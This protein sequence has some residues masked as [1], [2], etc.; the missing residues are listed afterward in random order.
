MHVDVNGARMWFD[1]EGPGL[2][3]DGGEMRQRPTVVLLHGGPGVFDHSYLKPDYARLADVAQVVYLDLLGHGRSEWGDPDAWTFEAAAD[4]VRAF[5]DAVGIERPV[6]LG[7]S[8]GTFVALVYG[9]R[10]PDHPAALV[11][12]SVFGRFDLDRIAD[13]FRR[14]GGDRAGEIARL[15]YGGERDA[16]ANEEWRPVWELVG[17]WVI[18][19]EERARCVA[20]I[21]L[22]ARGLAEMQRFDVL[23][24]LSAIRCPSLV[25]VG[26][27]DPITP[28]AAAREVVDALPDGVGRLEVFE[29]AGHFMWRD[30]PERYW[31]LLE[32]FVRRA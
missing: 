4:A 9:V 22:N 29:G 6:V 2:V 18:G 25:C 8:L 23:G 19:D 28:V 10:H 12:V 20:N 27:L 21:A 31:P 16:V 13:E 32:E 17:P 5:C 30:A 26:E 7:H 3:P 15:V 11:L 1:V 24:E 14:R